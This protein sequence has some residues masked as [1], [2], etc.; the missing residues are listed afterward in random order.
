MPATENRKT[1]RRE[2]RAAARREWQQA[3]RDEARQGVEETVTDSYAVSV[4]HQGQPLIDDAALGAVVAD[5]A[6]GA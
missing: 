5:W 3:L 1:T 4:G 6:T 2:Q